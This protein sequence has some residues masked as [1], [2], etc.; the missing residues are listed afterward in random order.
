MIGGEFLAADH[1]RDME[2]HVDDR[3]SA[4]LGLWAIRT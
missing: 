3:M 4:C 2:L 1:V